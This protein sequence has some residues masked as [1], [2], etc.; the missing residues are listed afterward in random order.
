MSQSQSQSQRPMH[1]SQ[2][3]LISAPLLL[4]ASKNGPGSR[5]VFSQAFRPAPPSSP[6]IPTTP[7]ANQN[8]IA[9]AL[10]LLLT[11]TESTLMDFSGKV[12]NL[13][14]QVKHAEKEI[15][16]VGQLNKEHIA[17]TKR[18]LQS[19]VSKS[20]SRLHDSISAGNATTEKILEEVANMSSSLEDHRRRFDVVESKLDR[21]T[22][23]VNKIIHELV[24]K[25]M[26]VTKKLEANEILL[27]D[28]R[29]LV[30]RVPDDIVTATREELA[31]LLESF[32]TTVQ[33]KGDLI[34]RRNYTGASPILK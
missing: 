8:Q 6:A 30:R 1:A 33:S 12:V 17:E 24:D 5:V 18:D 31:G 26:G 16:E 10:R 27:E 28:L 22:E 3:S 9:T 14:D 4:A 29:S 20:H 11:K 32:A 15:S 2:S 19:Y 34:S 21:C 25:V 7:T 23:D 13:V